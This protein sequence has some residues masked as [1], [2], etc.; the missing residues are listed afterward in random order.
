[1]TPSLPDW[2]RVHGGPVLAGELRRT[3]EDFE[4]R[5]I[6]DIDFTGDGEHDW[7]LVEKRGSNTDWIAR[8]LARA[9]GVAARD[10]GYAGLKDRHAL[11]SQWFSV[12]RAPGQDVDWSAWTV[13]G[14]R[15]LRVERHQKKLR[16]G[17]HAGNRFRITVR[18]D[19]SASAGGLLAERV[20]RVRAA[21]V[22]NYFGE[23]RFGRNAANLDLARDVLAGRRVKRFER[24]IALSAARSYLFNVIL[25][26]R[27]RNA[28]WD[29]ILEGERA[30]LDGSGSVFDV[31]DAGGDIQRRCEAFDLH[32]TATLWGRGAPLA[33]GALAV[34]ETA[35]VQGFDALA[36]AF[37]AGLEQ[38]AIDADSRATRLP[39]RELDVDVSTKAVRFDFRLGRG[40][41]ATAVLRELVSAP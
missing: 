1:M 3:P 13:D 16:R 29:R 38:A 6:L 31:D 10:V 25:D 15:V 39:V 36:A 40:A 11:T 37:A 8:Q 12:R 9:G 30:N 5:E 18:H 7:L 20:E 33:K 4:V 22:P 27:V 21:G 19:G 28:S 32:P 41:Y 35:T 14:A 23:Q 17:A 2:A 34:F 24:G 26:A